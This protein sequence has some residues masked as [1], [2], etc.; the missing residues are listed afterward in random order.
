MT[1]ST[2]ST[3][4]TPITGAHLRAPGEPR[5]DR[6]AQR[7]HVSFLRGRVASAIGIQP[8]RFVAVRAVGSCALRT[9]E[10]SLPLRVVCISGSSSLTHPTHAAAV[11]GKARLP[12]RVI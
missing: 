11:L 10:A 12:V 4:R 7:L 3:S 8:R 5:L 2:G 6:W 1:T 9:L